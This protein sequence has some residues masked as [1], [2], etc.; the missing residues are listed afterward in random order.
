MQRRRTIVAAPGRSSRVRVDRLSVHRLWIVA[1]ALQ[2]I[3]V[4]RRATLLPFRLAAAVGRGGG[5]DADCTVEI[6]ESVEDR[7]AENASCLLTVVV[8]RPQVPLRSI[9][10]SALIS[11]CRYAAKLGL[12]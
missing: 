2:S 12:F 4:P 11:V 3:V 7:R 9:G 1:Q 5:G 10:R 6:V 8:E